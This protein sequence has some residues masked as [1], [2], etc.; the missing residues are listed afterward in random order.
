MIVNNSLFR[1][2]GSGNFPIYGAPKP[3]D[4]MAKLNKKIEDFLNI[5]MK[6]I[7]HLKSDEES[8]ERY[9]QVLV[10]AEKVTEANFH[11]RFSFNP[12]KGFRNK[13]FIPD[14][15]IMLGHLRRE[16]VNLD[17]EIVSF[18]KKIRIN[19]SELELFSLSLRLFSRLREAMSVYLDRIPKMRI[20]FP[21]WYESTVKKLIKELD[22]LVKLI[23]HLADDE[24]FI[25][26][27]DIRILKVIREIDNEDRRLLE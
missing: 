22:I 18:E 1:T 5:I 19:Q 20:D 23:E 3:F 15:N 24:D 8:L 11:R 9:E 16:V 25:N 13:D 21:K 26:M 12:L 6:I 10:A 17:S 7:T 27:T 2:R 4:D 14:H